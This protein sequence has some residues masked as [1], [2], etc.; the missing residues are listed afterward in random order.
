VQI[1]TATNAPKQQQLHYRPF[2][3]WLRV[4]RMGPWLLGYYSPNG[5]NFQYVNAVFLPSN[6][7]LEVGLAAFTNFGGPST[8]VFSN[9]TVAGGAPDI[10]RDAG[11]GVPSFVQQ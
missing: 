5:I 3:T 11:S 4:Q 2:P 1:R 10:Y 8:A 9:V 7:C 6:N